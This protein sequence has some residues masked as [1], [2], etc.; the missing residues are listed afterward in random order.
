[1]TEQYAPAD[2]AAGESDLIAAGLDTHESVERIGGFAA[3]DEGAG[4]DV[5]HDGRAFRLVC[6][7]SGEVIA[8]TP[9]APVAAASAAAW[10]T[11]YTA[12]EPDPALWRATV[13]QGRAM[14]GD[15]DTYTEQLEHQLAESRRTGVL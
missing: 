14:L 5:L 8:T 9:H 7:E 4:V 6:R 3:T 15:L 10:L 13:A 11:T 1:M 2:E 12:A